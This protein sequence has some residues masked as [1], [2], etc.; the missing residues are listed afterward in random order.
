MAE[1]FTQKTRLPLSLFLVLSSIFLISKLSADE[2]FS[3]DAATRL[4]T[5]YKNSFSITGNTLLWADDTSQIMDDKI[6]KDFDT[7]LEQ[8]DIQDQFF[9]PYPKGRLIGPPAPNNDPG[10]IR[11]TDF[12]KKLYGSSPNEVENSL[13]S[14]I[15]LPGISGEKILFNTRHGAYENLEKVSQALS[16]LDERFHKYLLTIGGTYKWRP[17]EGYNKSSVR[18]HPKIHITRYR[19]EKVRQRI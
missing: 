8:A 17:M 12:F 5:F 16:H 9:I 3:M 10:R 2:T 7:L 19:D 15:W 18:K 13:K 6:L 4:L 11:N 14:L 1:S